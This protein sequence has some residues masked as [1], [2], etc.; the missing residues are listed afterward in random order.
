MTIEITKLADK[1]RNYNYI[2]DAPVC[3][4]CAIELADELEAALPKWTK[5]T[6]DKSWPDDGEY[7]WCYGSDSGG[8]I[9]ATYEIC[10]MRVIG[11]M[12]SDLYWR[13]LCDLDYPPE[14]PS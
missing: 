3:G 6:D 10:M 11:D 8:Y 7:L 5:I 13:P 12:V 4:D 1:W 2:E 9:H 14:P